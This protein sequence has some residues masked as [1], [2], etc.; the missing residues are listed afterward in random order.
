MT[1]LSLG[2]CINSAMKM[3]ASDSSRLSS[4]WQRKAQERGVSRLPSSG[5]NSLCNLSAGLSIT[6]RNK[7]P[8]AS[9][10]LLDASF[11][12]TATNTSKS[13]SRGLLGVPPNNFSGLLGGKLGKSPSRTLK[14]SVRQKTPT[15]IT[16]T[17]PGRI[18]E[19]S[20]AGDRFIPVRPKEMEL[21]RS[22][23]L[24][25]EQMRKDEGLIV[26]EEELTLQ[27]REHRERLAENLNDGQPL[28]QRIVHFSTQAPKNNNPVN[29][30]K[31]LYS[32]T[33][34][35]ASK[36][37]TTRHIPS[38]P[39][40]V[41]DAPEFMD[42]YY[43]H[44]VDWSCNNHVVVALG[45]S[46]Y[47]WNAGDGSIANLTQVESPDYICSLSWITDGSV[48][49]VGLSTGEVQLWDV[50]QEKLMRTMAGHEG[51]VATLAWRGA[52]LM[53]SG[54]RSGQII[55]HDVRVAQHA[56]AVVNAHNQEVCGLAWNS[57][58]RLLASGGNDN[59][60]NIWDARNTTALHRLSNHQAAVK[61]VAWCPWQS[62]VLGTGGGTADRTIRI[63]NANSGTCIKDVLTNSQVSSLVWN[64]SYKELITGHG[65]SHHQ[66]TIWKYPT[67]TKVADLTGHTGRVLELVASPDGQ[68]VAS[69][70]AD[71]TIRLWKCWP[72]QVK[73][74]KPG[75]SLAPV[76]SLA[77]SI[78]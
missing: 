58:G 55:H 56:T 77:K 57:E 60:V 35:S 46:V 33:K 52:A 42:D 75:R 4:R 34:A 2:S 26:E 39:E 3:D 51:R 36:T 70:A 54:A 63:W 67:F 59:I 71:E 22:Q 10:F 6:P 28:D 32:A 62:S 17:T 5:E 40:R 8:L 37:N 78:R 12:S 45:V 68:M 24:I 30:H 61:A 9:S 31:V 74:K 20:Y 69:A 18:S 47:V 66:L 64:A 48:L 11:G 7:T 38:E 25:M 27:Q 44:L 29:S 53:S 73:D 15:R 21:E 43:L 65:F 19:N 49:A 72:T 1:H 76:S 41:L 13:P 14:L 50:G 16:P 23:Q